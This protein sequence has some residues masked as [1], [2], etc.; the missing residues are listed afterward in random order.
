[1]PHPDYPARICNTII[2]EFLASATGRYVVFRGAVNWSSIDLEINKVHIAVICG[3]TDLKNESDIDN[4]IPVHIE[5]Y[6]KTRKELGP[7]GL[8]DDTLS[9]IRRDIWIVMERLANM[10]RDCKVRGEDGVPDNDDLLITAWS[11]VAQ[12]SYSHELEAMGLEADL[13]IKF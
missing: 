6:T 8:D 12:E 7:D 10:N 1:M 9:D 4:E 13:D 3:D 11:G 2:R 5:A